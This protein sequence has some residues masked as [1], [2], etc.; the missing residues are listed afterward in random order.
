MTSKV[1][2]RLAFGLILLACGIVTI[3][4]F[5]AGYFS[6]FG[7]RLHTPWNVVGS[8]IL[9]IALLVIVWKIV[10]GPKLDRRQRNE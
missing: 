2:F 5:W 7:L 6:R 1:F 9:L 4:G 10:A 3:Y 8:I